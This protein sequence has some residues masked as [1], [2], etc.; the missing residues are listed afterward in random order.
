[1]TVLCFRLLFL[2][3]IRQYHIVAVN[4]DSALPVFFA[5][6]LRRFPYVYEVLDEFALSYNFPKPIKKIAQ[7]L[8][9]LA[10]RHAKFVIH[11]DTNRVNYD[12]C[13][14]VIIENAPFDFYEGKEKNYDSLAHS[15]AI[16]GHLSE[17]RG[18]DSILLFA[19]NHPEIS[20]IMIGGIK[21]SKYKSMLQDYPN[22]SYH[23]FMEQR[24]VFELIQ[25]CC[26]IFSLYAPT[27]EINRLA[28]SNKVYDA[29]MLGVPVITN[30]EVLNSKFIKEH[31]IGIIVDY[32]CNETWD[33]LVADDY[34]QIAQKLGKNGR[35]LYLKKYRFDLMLTERFFPLFS[36]DI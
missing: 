17:I 18:I 19:K 12:K 27:T 2:K 20:F 14:S 23:P 15:F 22:I 13:R 30:Q 5:S 33:F 1:M 21:S 10:M 34:L 26:G 3:N 32:V 25:N 36:N 16:I 35:A 7:S 29:M 9:H 24:K 28:A 6:R 31:E 4:F 8:D 11:V